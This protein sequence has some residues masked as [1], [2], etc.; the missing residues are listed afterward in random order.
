M[1]DRWQGAHEPEDVF[2][3]EPPRD[4]ELAALLAQVVGVAPIVDVDWTALSQRISAA[5]ARQRTAWWSYAARWERRAVP[6]ALAA[7]LAGALALWGLGIPA[8]PRP[9]TVAMLSDPVAAMVEGA[10]AADAARSYARSIT[11][12]ADAST[13]EPW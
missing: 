11:S 8:A 7:G 9:A 1:T 10:P 12:A 2:G 5:S 13:V 3:A 6:V 4:L